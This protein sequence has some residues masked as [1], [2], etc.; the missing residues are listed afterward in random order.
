MARSSKIKPKSIKLTVDDK[1]I[2]IKKPSKRNYELNVALLNP[3]KY[4]EF[5]E[6]P[7]EFCSRYDLAIDREI[8]DQLK[9]RLQDFKSLDDMRGML[10]VDDPIPDTEATLWAIAQGIFSVASTKALIAF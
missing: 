4:K 2:E 5:V 10:S 8:S 6:N 7:R 1:V 9:E 3:E